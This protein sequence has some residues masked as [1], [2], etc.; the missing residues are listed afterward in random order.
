MTTL[1]L[2]CEF[3]FNANPQYDDY[4]HNFHL[5]PNPTST[6]GT[7]GK[8]SIA[9]GGGQCIKFEANG[10][11]KLTKIPQGYRLQIT[12]Y[13]ESDPYNHTAEKKKLDNVDVTFFIEKGVPVSYTHLRAHETL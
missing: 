2:T 7:V 1:D 10:N 4:L 13:Y 3:Y 6:D 12:D 9:D 8:I 11:Y 5:Q